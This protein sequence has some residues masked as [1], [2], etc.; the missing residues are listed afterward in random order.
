MS[1]F[2]IKLAAYCSLGSLLWWL[3]TTWRLSRSSQ[4]QMRPSH[5]RDKRIP[6]TLCF[7][8]YFFCCWRSWGWSN[9][10]ILSLNIASK[11][12]NQESLSHHFFSD[13]SWVIEVQLFLYCSSS[14]VSEAP[15]VFL[16]ALALRVTN[17]SQPLF[18]VFVF[19]WRATSS[20]KNGKVMHLEGWNIYR[21]AIFH[22]S[23]RRVSINI[24]AG[25]P[26]NSELVWEAALQFLH[27]SIE[28]FYKHNS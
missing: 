3:V 8:S 2:W 1:S 9:D 21:Q 13:E 19:L 22:Y 10:V 28:L 25:L 27:I 15:S 18:P 23:N 7:N 16:L 20:G 14:S 26:A 24:S 5:K 12:W 6:V 11:Q 4:P 17:G